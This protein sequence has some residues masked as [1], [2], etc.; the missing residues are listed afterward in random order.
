MA[1]QM[2]GKKTRKKR[3]YKDRTPKKAKIE[4]LT[5]T[6]RW[7]SHFPAEKKHGKQA[8]MRLF[9]RYQRRRGKERWQRDTHI[10]SVG[11]VCQL[12]VS[13]NDLTGNCHFVPWNPPVVLLT[14]NSPVVLVIW[15]SSVV[16]VT[17]NSPI[18]LVNW[19]SPIVSV[20]SN[21]PVVLVTWK[22]SAVL[23][24]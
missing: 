8:L 11:F 4:L 7:N 14:S 16:S 23:V 9:Q 13:N 5:L 12:F 15:N 24:T 22:L 10:S 18:I 17:W 3:Q 1:S 2:N 19:N 6:S 20:T 21:S